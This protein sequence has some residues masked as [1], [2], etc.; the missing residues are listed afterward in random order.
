MARYNHILM[1]LSVQYMTKTR[2]YHEGVIT[3]CH[4][5]GKTGGRWTVHAKPGVLLVQYRVQFELH[6]MSAFPYNFSPFIQHAGV[7]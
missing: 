3:A 2:L 6:L 7:R 1:M 4:P 5:A